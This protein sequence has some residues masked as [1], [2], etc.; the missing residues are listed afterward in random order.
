MKKTKTT[1][2]TFAVLFF[3]TCLTAKSGAEADPNDILIIANSR[4]SENE[5]SVRELKTLFTKRRKTWKDGSQVIPIDAKDASLRKHFQEKVLGMT[6][7][8]ST[9]FWQN[10]KIRHGISAPATFSNTQRATFA[11]KGSVSYVWRRDYKKGVN[12][13]ILVVPN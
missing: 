3:A 10:Q 5:I 2:I 13:V 4:V 1:R 8:Q 6:P 7:E 9:L 11:V 12:K